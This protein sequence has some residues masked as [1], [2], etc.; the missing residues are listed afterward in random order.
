LGTASKSPQNSNST[1]SQSTHSP[2]HTQ[3]VSDGH[4]S[5]SAQST[6]STPAPA[7]VTVLVTL[8]QKDILTPRKNAYKVLYDNMPVKCGQCGIRFPPSDDIETKQRDHMD[9]HFRQNRQ[10]KTK[11]SSAR[12]WFNSEN[13]WIESKESELNSQQVPMFFNT[14]ADAEEEEKKDDE[15][16][17]VLVPPNHENPYCPICKDK[18]QSVWSDAQEDWVYNNAVQIDDV[19][20]ITNIIIHNLANLCFNRSI[21]LIA[22]KTL[23]N[24]RASPQ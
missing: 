5:G 16:H 15:V 4:N 2:Q 21:M 17:H 8:N 6:S 13:D 9:W 23:Q 18:F 20:S 1:R 11:K 12:N 3:Q 10:S 19:V 7:F 24:L 14:E 22:I